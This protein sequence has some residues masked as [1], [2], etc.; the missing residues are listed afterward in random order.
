M[1]KETN[2]SRHACHEPKG[3]IR[4]HAL[5]GD[6][7]PFPQPDHENAL[8]KFDRD[9]SAGSGVLSLRKGFNDLLC[10]PEGC[11]LIGGFSLQ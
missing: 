3:G 4:Y 10:G 5:V 2:G 9:L 1:G 7:G 8:H 11:F 6:L